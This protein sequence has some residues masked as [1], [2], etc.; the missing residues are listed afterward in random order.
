MLADTKSKKSLYLY[1]KTAKNII[2]IYFIK[3]LGCRFCLCKVHEFFF[4][5]KGLIAQSVQLRLKKITLWRI[6]IPASSQRSFAAMWHNNK[7]VSQWLQCTSRHVAGILGWVAKTH[8]SCAHGNVP[9]EEFVGSQENV[10]PEAG[11]AW[12]KYTSVLARVSPPRGA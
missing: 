10:W 6:I 2:Y 9:G 1:Y 8:G 4:Q 5:R 12:P 7:T 11:R 3:G